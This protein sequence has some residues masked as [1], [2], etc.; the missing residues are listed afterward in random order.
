MAWQDFEKESTE[1][2]IEYIRWGEK[3]EHKGVAEDAF[4]AFFFRFRN[5]VQRKCRIIC[6]HQG[7]DDFVADEVAEKTFERFLKYPNYNH[8]KC[9]S[10]N[11]DTCVR[12]YLYRFAHNI[13]SDYISGE[14]RPPNPYTGAEEIVTEFPEFAAADVP[15]ERRAELERKQE[16][17]QKALARLSPKHK[18]VYLT[19]SKYEH[20]GYNLPRAFQK[21]L[22]DHLGLTQSSI[23]VYKKEAFD[24]I[25]EYIEIYGAK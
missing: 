3:P 8:S 13:L 7:Y 10:G 22:Q 9:K 6:K 18:T 16:V 25:K 14:N 12:L 4:R 20:N 24:K 19:Y 17:I 15:V 21:R 23:R 5:D 11:V 1:D 2:L